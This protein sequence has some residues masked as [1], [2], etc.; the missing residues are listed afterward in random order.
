MCIFLNIECLSEVNCVFSDPCT[1]IFS[2]IFNSWP[3]ELPLILFSIKKPILA[4]AY[5]IQ[6]QISLSFCLTSFML[7]QGSLIFNLQWF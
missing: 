7:K 4:Q 2:Y 1:N 6:K 3:F 5:I